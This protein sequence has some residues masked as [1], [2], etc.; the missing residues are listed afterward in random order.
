MASEKRIQ[1]I[2]KEP[3]ERIR[4]MLC[5]HKHTDGQSAIVPL[6][7]RIDQCV[8]CLNKFSKRPE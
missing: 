1:E 3:N 5:D 7:K 8:I 4:A 2:R 6:G